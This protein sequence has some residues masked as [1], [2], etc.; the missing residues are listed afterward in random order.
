MPEINLY[1]RWQFKLKLKVSTD[2]TTIIRTAQVEVSITNTFWRKHMFM[3][4][5]FF[6]SK[7]LIAAIGY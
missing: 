7:L 5:N 4:V 3:L 2:I 6:G 1:F